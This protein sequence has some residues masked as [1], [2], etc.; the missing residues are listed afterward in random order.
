[1]N[2]PVIRVRA[3][4]FVPTFQIVQPIYPKEKDEEKA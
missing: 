3:E 4:A 2:I 1:M